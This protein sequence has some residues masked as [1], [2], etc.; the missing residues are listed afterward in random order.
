MKYYL[1]DWIL[2]LSCVLGMMLAMPSHALVIYDKTYDLS[3]APEP[4][5][6]WSKAGG[7]TRT[8]TLLSTASNTLTYTR[9]DLALGNREAFLIE[10]VVSAG[11]IGIQG[12]R[13]ARLW[14]TF[15]D[16][17]APGLPPGD[18]SRQVEVRLYEDAIGNR[19]IAL[20]DG[21]TGSEMASLALD[22]STSIPALRIRLMR[23]LVGG[24]DHML[25]QAGSSGAG[26]SQMLST[27]AAL[28]NFGFLLT[29]ANELGFGHAISSTFN[30]NWES[31]RV[32]ATDDRATLLPPGSGSVPNLATAWLVWAGMLGWLGIAWRK[33]A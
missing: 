18:K 27:Q 7:G 19:N 9:N 33:A 26:E 28:S 30:S 23:Q 1:K 17:D 14:A 2:A 29:N 13:G 10:A 15:F 21:V 11:P 3:T 24:I 31:I 20:Y 32:I 22:W 5:P 6:D 12:E 16:P 4:I 8:G 25:L